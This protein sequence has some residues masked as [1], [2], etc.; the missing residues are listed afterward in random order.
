L[1]CLDFLMFA[2]GFAHRTALALRFEIESTDMEPPFPR[3]TNAIRL[4]RQAM[5]PQPYHCLSYFAIKGP[6]RLLEIFSTSPV[7]ARQLLCVK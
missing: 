4:R 2:V 1:K 6:W 7:A 5:R 3:V